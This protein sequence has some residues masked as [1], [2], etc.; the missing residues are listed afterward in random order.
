MKSIAQNCN[1]FAVENLVRDLDEILAPYT[2]NQVFLLVDSGSN[3]HCVS[4]LRGVEKISEA[5]TI[6]IK[7]GDENKDYNAAVDI[8]NFLSTHGAT[9]KAVLVN[10]GGGMPCDLGGFCAATFKRGIDFVNIPTTLLAQ[11]DASLGGKTGMNL[12]SLK[13][14]IGVFSIA[15]NVL[16]DGNFLRTL[17]KPNLLSG[18]AE[19]IKHA[20]IHD[21]DELD[22]LVRFDFEKPDYEQLQALVCKSIQIKNHFV[23]EDPKEK[24]VRKALNFGHTFG[25]AFETF[26]MRKFTDGAAKDYILHGH[27][28]A[29]GI[30]CELLMSREKLGLDAQ[31]V[32]RMAT[33]INSLYGKFHFTNADFDVLGELMRHD[34]KNDTKGINFTLLPRL[35][36]IEINQIGTPDDIARTLREYQ[37]L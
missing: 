14:E 6:V 12:Y 23:T 25:H 16:I 7:N 9:R 13:N 18:Y 30:V 21:A 2:E 22:N 27:A 34:K 33:Y 1:V 36:Q 26:S 5:R 8:W 29:F 19:M 20:L 10:L 32:Q 24:G 35:G 37:E 31:S 11:V 4:A 28:V 3:L 15:K 17:D